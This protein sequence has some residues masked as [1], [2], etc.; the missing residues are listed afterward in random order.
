[1]AAARAVTA[2]GPGRPAT[3][4]R[5][6]VAGPPLPLGPRRGVAVHLARGRRVPAG[7]GRAVLRLLALLLR[8]LLDPVPAPLAVLLPA[9]ALLAIDVAVVAG[10]DVAAAGPT[11]RRG[12]G[13]PRASVRLA[14]A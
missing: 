9:V 11:D 14:A 3:S 12:A 8:R 5:A 7:A 10:V 4:R 2:R 6:R 13:R 1:A